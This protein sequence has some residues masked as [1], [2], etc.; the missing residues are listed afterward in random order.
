MSEAV[1][2]WP[3]GIVIPIE[4]RVEGI[5]CNTKDFELPSRL[6]QCYSPHL[7]RSILK[8][9]VPFRRVGMFIPEH[10]PIRR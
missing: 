3:A 8:A 1:V 5:F 2:F 9:I 6:D 10:P 7:G 4:E